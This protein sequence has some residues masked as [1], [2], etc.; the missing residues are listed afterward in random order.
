[1][2]TPTPDAPKAQVA[3]FLKQD[4]QVPGQN[5]FLISFADPKDR[6][7]EDR[8]RY[9]MYRYF[10]EMLK[11]DE[12]VAEMQLNL[13]EAET[14]SDKVQLLADDYLGWLST[15]GVK[16]RRDFAEEF[17]EEL[18]LRAVKIRGVFSMREDADRK[19]KELQKTDPYFSIYLGDVGKWMPGFPDSEVRHR[20]MA[21]QYQDEQ[22][23][24]LI[25]ENIAAQ[26][27]SQASFKKR[28]Q[29]LVD[30][31]IPEEKVKKRKL[32]RAQY[33]QRLRELRR[34]AKK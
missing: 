28:Q 30:N 21:E 7:I 9:E 15:N 19:A 25:S 20:D 12:Q 11:S 16:V 29:E 1:M 22:L 18:A 23:S 2:T 27:Q 34:T 24:T 32:T 14:M 4:P 5:Y 33:V 31:P 6:R 13:G 10:A 17:G 3:D 8:V 26:E